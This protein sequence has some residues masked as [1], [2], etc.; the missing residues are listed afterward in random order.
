MREGINKLEV[1]V[2]DGGQLNVA[3]DNG[4]VYA[5]QNN[6]NESANIKQKVK[7]RTQEYAEIWNKN[8]FL[9]NFD[10]WDENA[11]VNVKLSD[12]YIDKHLPHFK[13]GHNEKEYDNLDILLSKYIIK[14]NENKMLLILG[15]PGIGKSTLITWIV[16]K[17]NEY[18]ENILVYKFADDLKNVNWQNPNVSERILE[19]LNLSYNDL[20]RKTLILDGF[21][22]VSIG[23]DRKEVLDN[24]YG[25][26]IY[27]KNIE[28]FSLIITCREN[29]IQKFERV[30]CKYIILQPWDKIHITSFCNIFQEKTKNSVSDST[31]EKFIENKEVFGIPLILYMV[32]ALEISIEKDSSIVDVYDKIFSLEGGIYDRCINNKNFSDTHRIGGM[33]KQIHQVSR[34]MAMWM[35]ENVPD[36]AFIPQK[37]YEN[38]CINVIKEYQYEDENIIQDSQIGNYFKKVKH[39]EGVET[40]KILFVHRSLYEYFAT[41]YLFMSLEEII[42]KKE[43]E[44]TLA[45][46]L[47]DML[48][49]NSLS[50]EILGYLKYKIKKSILSTKFD[51]FRE[52]FQLMLNC[53]MTYFTSKCYRNV[54][55][56]EMN[57]FS[58]MLEILHLW[59]DCSLEFDDTI[60]DYLRYNSRCVLNLGKVKFNFNKSENIINNDNLYESLNRMY[61]DGA[62]LGGAVLEGINLSGSSLIGA[63]LRFSHL[64]GSNLRFARCGF[65][66]YGYERNRFV[67]NSVKWCRH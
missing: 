22:E 30:K 13:Y 60:C 63:N 38:I 5:A 33:K 3:I 59:E 44:E 37:E 17:F 10:E 8:M 48:K 20:G 66:K 53:G 58:N 39:C 43:S 57:V 11:G 2:Q 47:G 67:G 18:I 7:S 40:E 50:K 54:I 55:K 61:L 41:E 14:P 34:E 12:V 21:D 32:L 64:K 52:T 19:T 27:K 51:F 29:Y 65:A 23:V 62:N 6:G 26:L 35:F 9:N 4:M 46:K 1:H 49:S 36:E 31:K 16:T 28:K 24:L 25:K 15:Q 42:K 45:A 56:C